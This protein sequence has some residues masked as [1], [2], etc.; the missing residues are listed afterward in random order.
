MRAAS[1]RFGPTRRS[2]ARP[3]GPL[4]TRSRGSLRG[5]RPPENSRPPWSSGRTRPLEARSP[6]N[7]SAWGARVSCVRSHLRAGS[8][9]ASRSVCQNDPRSWGPWD[10]SP[11]TSRGPPA[12]RR[13]GRPR[14]PWSGGGGVPGRNLRRSGRRESDPRGARRAGTAPP[15]GVLAWSLYES[16]PALS[17][18]SRPFERARPVQSLVH[19]S[20]GN[21]R[22]LR[23]RLLSTDVLQIR[24]HHEFIDA[25]LLAGV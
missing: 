21:S 7:S 19:R 14:K 16:S 9:L 24:R 5:G 15:N 1:F 20:A 22:G 17:S 11:R 12:A 10:T 13:P 23:P 2:G 3:A 6:S 4:R 8:P 25:A 18:Y